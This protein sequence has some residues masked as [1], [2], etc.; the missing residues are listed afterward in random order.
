MVAAGIRFEGE[1]TLG[2]M[3]VAARTARLTIPAE[4]ARRGR[5][6]NSLLAIPVEN[7]W[8]QLAARRLAAETWRTG[9]VMLA[10][11]LHRTRGSRGAR[12]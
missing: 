6:R 2:G 1:R 8:Q 7:G 10:A 11:P 4:A 9:A 12:R 3:I 5:V